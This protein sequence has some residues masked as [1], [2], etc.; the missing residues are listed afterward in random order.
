MFIMHFPF[1]KWQVQE[2]ILDETNI[3][4][5]WRPWDVISGIGLKKKNKIRS[6]DKKIA[7]KMESYLSFSNMNTTFFLLFTFR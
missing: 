6:Y 7:L 2:D 5:Y 4:F 3:N 1:C